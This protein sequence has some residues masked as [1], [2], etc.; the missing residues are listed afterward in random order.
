MER[1]HL[2]LLGFLCPA[3]PGLA[4]LVLLLLSCFSC[5]LY[6]PSPCR[7]RFDILVLM[8]VC[9]CVCV[10]VLRRYNILLFIVILLIMLV[11]FFVSAHFMFGDKIMVPNP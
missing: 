11:G 9:V 7:N 1:K 3:F 8:C 5:C 2:P 6:S 4:C 10:C